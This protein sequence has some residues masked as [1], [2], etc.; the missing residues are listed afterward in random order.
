MLFYGCGK[1]LAIIKENVVL[2]RATFAK[3]ELVKYFYG[4]NYV[5]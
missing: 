5:L 3:I 1:I 4:G 2:F